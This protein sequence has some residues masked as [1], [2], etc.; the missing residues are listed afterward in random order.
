[1]VSLLPLQRLAHRPPIRTQL[2]AVPIAR[3]RV[4]LAIALVLALARAKSALGAGELEGQIRGRVVEAATNLPV[5][6]ATVTVTSPNLG[7]PRIVTTNEDGEYLAPSLPI[8]H[9]KVTVS[10]PGVKPMTRDILVQ[11]GTT[12]A[13][14][15]RWSAELTETETTERQSG[16]YFWPG[17]HKRPQSRFCD[18]P[19]APLRLLARRGR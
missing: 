18:A 16:R 9:Y 11:P 3:T 12:S 14:D 1:M 17:Q 5:P 2:I 10:Y 19:G 4:G 8:G 13:V 7:D 15:F 6:G